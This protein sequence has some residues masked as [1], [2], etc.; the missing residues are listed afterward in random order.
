M[1][2]FFYLHSKTDISDIL[3]VHRITHATWGQII[4]KGEGMDMK[5]N[6]LM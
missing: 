4:A 5:G 2:W 6:V 3:R 1:S